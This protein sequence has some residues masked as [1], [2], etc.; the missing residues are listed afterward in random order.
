MKKLDYSFITTGAA[1]PIKKGTL[2]HVQESYQEAIDAICRNLVSNPS[3]MTVL[4]GCVNTG[5]GA[6][7]I[8]SAGAVY[9]N[10]EVYLIDAATFTTSG[11]NVAVATITTTYYTDATADPVTFTDASTHNV[12][13]IRKIVIAAGLSGSGDANYSDFDFGQGQWQNYTIVNGDLA[14]NAGTW[15]LGGGSGILSYKKTGKTVVLD[16]LIL[17][18]NFS[19]DKSSVTINIPA[20]IGV[21]TRTF[22][23]M[24][25][26]INDED[27]TH[28]QQ[29][30]GGLVGTTVTFIEA[31]V[32]AKIHMSAYWSSLMNLY[33]DGSD[34][35]NFYGQLT[36]E[37]A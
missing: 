35:I 37:V 33:A 1:Q 30:A 19:S 7:F 18:T 20:A 25:K 14:A 34:N 5:S 3:L 10:G 29:N 23:S 17:S 36:F 13:Q 12:H 28:S 4:F 11:S 31:R 16:I 22:T 8:I 32:D 24:G 6:N 9:F 2:K 21:P 27:V 26:F 15:T